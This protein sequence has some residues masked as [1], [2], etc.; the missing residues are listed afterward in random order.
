[1]A[2]VKAHVLRLSSKG[3]LEKQLEDLKQE[4]RRFY[5]EVVEHTS[6]LN[7]YVRL[8]HVKNYT[9]VNLKYHNILHIDRYMDRCTSTNEVKI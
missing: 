6:T 5:L 7:L 9:D 8:T 2:A 1:M 3:D 4:V